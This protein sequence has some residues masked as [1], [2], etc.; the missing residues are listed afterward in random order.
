VQYGN[1]TPTGIYS[2]LK[3]IKRTWVINAIPA[4]PAGQVGLTYQYH[5]TAKGTMCTPTAIMEEGHFAGAAWNVDPAGQLTPSG[6]NPY[7]VGPFYPGGLDSAFVIGNQASIL[8]VSSSIQLRLQQAGS[9]IQL[10]WT[11]E[12]INGSTKY[13]IERSADGIGFT[14]LAQAAAGRYNYNDAAF[15]AGIYYYRIKAEAGGA[16]TYS[17]IVKATA[18]QPGSMQ[19]RIYPSLVTAATNLYI[20]SNTAGTTAITITDLAGRQVYATGAALH[21]GENKI[22][23]S[24]A[25]LPA[26]IYQ[27]RYNAGGSWYTGRVMKQ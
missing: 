19:P 13:Y 24:F 21:T 7:T 25:G 15:G 12:N 9:T 18:T 16:I 17:N 1:S 3:T 20:Y 6:S 11:A 8:A 27:V 5:D 4:A 22:A 14:T 10:Q 23:I 2:P 26:G